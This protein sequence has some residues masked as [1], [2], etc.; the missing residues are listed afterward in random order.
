MKKCSLAIKKMQIKMTL[1]FHLTS[2]RMV[3]IK[4]TNNNKCWWRCREKGTLIHCWW[5]YKL[6]QPLWKA[7][8]TFLNKPK[9]ELPHDPAIPL[10]GIYPKECK[11]G[12]NKGTCTPMFIAALFTIAKL[13]K[14][15]R[16]LTSDECI[17]NVVCIHNGA[18]F[19]NKETW[20]CV[21]CR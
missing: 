19:S 12:Y 5:K 11:S 2:V 8:W 20:N 10:L 14:Q 17:T 6:V 7:A 16:C 21:V 3:M 13:C 9:I 15:S 18:L 1:T 4:N